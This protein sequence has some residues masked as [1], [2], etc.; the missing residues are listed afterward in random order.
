MKT[1][2]YNSIELPAEVHIVPNSV[3]TLSSNAFENCYRLVEIVNNSAISITKGSGNGY[4]ALSIHGGIS[5]I[6]VVDDFMFLTVE[7]A[8]YLIG[9]KGNSEILELP[10]S[11]KGKAYIVWK[12]AF[13]G[14]S[15]IKSV[16]ISEG[17]ISIQNRAFNE[18]EN[19]ESFTISTSVTRLEQ[20][21]L[22]YCYNLKTIT[23]NGTKAEFNSISKA[24]DWNYITGTSVVHCSDG[25]VT[26]KY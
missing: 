17:V 11:Y 19:L 24:E 20:Y 26:T 16:V 4:Y 18:C 25:N 5:Q 14:C 7:D 8:N 21:T 9:Y 13:S 2:F 12:Y 10:N 3:T 22:L 23:F 15:T 6:E 1:L